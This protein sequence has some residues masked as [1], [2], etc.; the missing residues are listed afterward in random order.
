MC[1]LQQSAWYDSFCSWLQKNGHAALTVRAARALNHQKDGRYGILRTSDKC[2]VVIESCK[3]W[4][5]LYHDDKPW[6]AIWMFS[7]CYVICF[8]V[9]YGCLYAKCNMPWCAKCMFICTM[10]YSLVCRMY[11]YLYFACF[12]FCHELAKTVCPDFVICSHCLNCKWKWELALNLLNTIAQK[13]YL[14]SASYS[15]LHIDLLLC[16]L[17]PCATVHFLANTSCYCESNTDSLSSSCNAS[18]SD[19][20]I[21]TP[22]LWVQFFISELYCWSNVITPSKCDFDPPNTCWFFGYPVCLS[23]SAT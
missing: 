8:G 1:I 14:A 5:R 12:L 21:N 18:L 15:I 23:Y 20:G 3:L 17:P 7:L 10:K 9:Q 16:C 19:F 13:L 6:C 2:K 11:F 22:N 4:T